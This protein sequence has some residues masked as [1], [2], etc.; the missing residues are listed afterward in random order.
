[1]LIAGV[2]E[3]QIIFTKQFLYKE[4]IIKDLGYV[5]Y[6]LRLEIT[7]SKVG[8][9][10]NQRKYIMGM[11]QDAGLYHAKSTFYPLIKGIK[12]GSETGAIM[13]KS[14]KYRQ[15]VGNLLYLGDY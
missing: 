5:K 7:S 2:T 11:L 9:L 15:L 4:F 13:S 14:E 6:F 10:L 8:M 3:I 1:M 12:L